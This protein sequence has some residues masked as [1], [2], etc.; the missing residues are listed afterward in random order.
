MGGV[1]PPS[2]YA[3]DSNFYQIIRLIA[4]NGSGPLKS[5]VEKKYD[6]TSPESQNGIL[7]V[8]YR[9]VMT[10]LIDAIKGSSGGL[11]ALMVDDTRDVSNLEQ[12][13]LC[14]RYMKH[15]FTVSETFLGFI[16]TPSTTGECMYKQLRHT[17]NSLGLS[18]D[19]CRGQGYDGA[20]NMIE[21]LKGLATRVSADFPLA[22]F[23]YCTGHMLN[24]VVQDACKDSHTLKALDL[25]RAVVN[26]VKDSPKR[27]ASFSNFV[28]LEEYSGSIGLRPLCSTRWVCREPALKSFVQNYRALLQW[29]VEQTIAGS[30]SDKK[31]LL[32]T[33]I[34]LRNLEIILQSVSCKRYSQLCI[35]PI[36]PSRN[37]I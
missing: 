21:F 5:W 10:D 6:W 35:G 22:L 13:S 11:F 3:A 24:L 2:R 28:K 20:S 16:D 15:D 25:L 27:E 37:P 33:S 9:G 4:R 7:K 23:S 32:G 34:R 29:F 31:V 26:Y 18:L 17:L 8:L 19:E 1:T 30:P 14:L 36:W 12:M